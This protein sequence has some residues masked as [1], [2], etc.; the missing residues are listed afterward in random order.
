MK[1][2]NRV[3]IENG[4]SFLGL[5]FIVFLAL[6]LAN[7][8]DISWF[9]VFFPLFLSI[10]PFVIFIIIVIITSIVSAVFN[11]REKKRKP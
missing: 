1:D 5:L 2:N 6:K 3:I 9:W 11:H 4:V 7:F 8:I 10:L